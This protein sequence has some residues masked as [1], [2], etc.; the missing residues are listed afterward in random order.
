[1]A[2]SIHLPVCVVSG[3]MLELVLS[4]S[5]LTIA[6]SQVVDRSIRPRL[7][8][9]SCPDRQPASGMYNSSREVCISE[10]NSSRGLA[11]NVLS[12]DRYCGG[13]W[14]SIIDKLDYLQAGGWDSVWIS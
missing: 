3:Q 11:Y 9:R 14:R 8:H 5:V 6:H 12:F 1:M 4:W 7:G 2:N 13:T 10:S